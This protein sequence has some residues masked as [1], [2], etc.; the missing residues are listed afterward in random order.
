MET[1]KSFILINLQIECAVGAV[2]MALLL[3]CVC[4]CVCGTA[5]LQSLC[6]WCPFK[7]ATKAKGHCVNI[8]NRNAENK[9][10]PITN[11]TILLQ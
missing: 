10:C 5:G 9:L 1:W 4:W 11:N 2:P 7:A 8:A 6:G 3:L